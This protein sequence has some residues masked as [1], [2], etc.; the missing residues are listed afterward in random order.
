MENRT[1]GERIGWHAEKAVHLRRVEHHRHYLGRARGLQQIGDEARGDADARRVFLVR[2]RERK[3]RNDR[4][5]L[6]R[7]GGARNV[8]HH[9]EFHQIIV[10]GR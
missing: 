3:V 8:Q 7:G 6:F 2:A 5:D 4:V 10:H 9:Q 1:T